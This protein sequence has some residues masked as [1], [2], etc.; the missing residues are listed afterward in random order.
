MFGAFLSGMLYRLSKGRLIWAFL[1]E[2]I[3]TGI[4][5]AVISYP[6]MTFIWGRNGLSWM[7]YVPSFIAGTL[8][9]GSIAF[10]MLTK[11]QKAGLVAKI[12][13]ALGSE[14][15]TGGNEVFNN[16]VGIAVLGF[17][18]YLV[19]LVIVKNFVSEPTSFV[20]S[21]KYLVLAAFVLAGIIYWAVN[22]KKA[23]VS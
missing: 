10:F 4:I 16:S 22:K 23:G 19:V 6:V 7:F 17:I 15:Y 21:L 11:M 3:G 14:V 20:N 2:V 13:S 12:Q 5:G 8:I 1:G 9:G 18:A